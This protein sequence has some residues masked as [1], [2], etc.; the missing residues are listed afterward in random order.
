MKPRRRFTLV[1]GKEKLG[2]MSLK[3]NLSLFSF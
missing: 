3:N 2:Q 1:L